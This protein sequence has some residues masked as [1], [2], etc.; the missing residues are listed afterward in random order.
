MVCAERGANIPLDL[1]TFLQW[2]VGRRQHESGSASFG[3][4]PADTSSQPLDYHFAFV[5]NADVVTKINALVRKTFSCQQH[6]RVSQVQL[7]YRLAKSEKRISSMG[8]KLDESSGLSY[9]RTTS[10]GFPAA[11]Y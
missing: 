3:I 10:Q 2:I 9:T 1:R 11:H 7:F 8:A 5:D 4:I 6:K